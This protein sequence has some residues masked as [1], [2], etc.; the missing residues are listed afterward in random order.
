MPSNNFRIL[1]ILFAAM[2]IFKKMIGL[3]VVTLTLS[4]IILL[5]SK[6]CEYKILWWISVMCDGQSHDMLC[7]SQ[8]VETC[9]LCFPQLIYLKF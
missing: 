7:H 6:Y 9:H 8:F 5:K 2:S 3:A 4:L 1:A